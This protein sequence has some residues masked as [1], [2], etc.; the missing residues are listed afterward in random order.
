MIMAKQALASVVLLILTASAACNGHKGPA[1]YKI[2]PNGELRYNYPPRHNEVGLD[3][4]TDHIPWGRPLA[5]GPVKAL[6]IA[7]RY[8]L[9]RLSNWPSV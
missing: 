6:V 7:N 5:G 9:A 4:V 8:N 3:Y 2:L 1:Y